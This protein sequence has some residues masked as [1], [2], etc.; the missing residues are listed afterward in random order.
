ME[1]N[2]ILVGFDGSP[3][4]KKALDYAKYLSS[5]LNSSITVLTVIRLPDFSSSRDE[6]D[7]EIIEA[8]KRIFPMHREIVELGKKENITI[9]TV[10]IHGHPV[11]KIIDYAQE[12]E[13]DLIIIGTRGL[14]GFKKLVIGS[15]AQKVVS[16]SKVPVMVVKE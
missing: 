15:V 10:I 11:E 5:K 7:E 13:F 14:G 9:N 16:Y 1:M 12:N 4:S 3:S 8:G 2:K 6:V